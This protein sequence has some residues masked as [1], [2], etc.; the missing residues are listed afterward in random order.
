MACLQWRYKI[1][2]CALWAWQ[3]AALV[4]TVVCV[5]L[6]ATSARL[7]PR[8]AILASI[9]LALAL[10]SVLGQ[11]RACAAAAMSGD[12]PCL[13]LC[14]FPPKNRKEILRGLGM[15]DGSKETSKLCAKRERVSV[16]GSGFGYWSWR[17]KASHQRLYTH[18]LAGLTDEYGLDS[19]KY[20]VFYAGTTIVDAS[21]CMD[22]RIPFRPC[23]SQKERLLRRAGRGSTFWSHPSIATIS[24]GAWFMTSC[25]GNGAQA[26]NP[27]SRGL[28][29]AELVDLQTMTIHQVYDDGVDALKL[30]LVESATQ[31]TQ[32]PSVYEKIRCLADAEQQPGRY[33][34]VAVGFRKFTQRYS[35]LPPILSDAKN[36]NSLAPNVLVVKEMCNVQIGNEKDMLQ[37]CEKWLDAKAVLR[38]LFIGRAAP[39]LALG[40]RW[41]EFNELENE[42]WPQHR[43][44]ASCFLCETEHI[45]EHDCS[46]DCRAAQA[47]T[48]RIV[49]GLYETNTDR[50]KG[51]STLSDAN[52]FTPLSFP[53]ALGV[54]IPS[55]GFYN[56]E[57]ACRPE[58]GTVKTPHICSL[59]KK[60]SKWHADAGCR[61]FYSGFGRTEIRCCSGDGNVIW[62]DFA[63]TSA[64]FKDAF[65]IVMEA[66]LPTR[67]ALHNGKYVSKE[68]KNAFEAAKEEVKKEVREYSP[69]PLCTPYE[70]FYNE[71]EPSIRVQLCRDAPKLCTTCMSRV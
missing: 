64:S 59:L 71:D 23:E 17:E 10:G 47:D 14:M 63:V 29:F 7:E 20:F 34:L 44:L 70:C 41:V 42:E 11:L 32:V 25:H 43:R 61:P 8:L 16:V 58:G 18:R 55:L 2:L 9:T 65:K 38:V 15:T 6:I 24:L 40:I 53:A 36:G 66:L 22:D 19:S 69:P 1:R 45:D 60:L 13:V 21:R 26:G 68:L 50:W 33:V 30:R 48:C 51:V 49:C 62:V 39:K 12:F 46:R 31:A 54:L 28:C 67:L 57:M 27:S 52:I 5:L 56:F 35:C 37:Q 3:P 4:G